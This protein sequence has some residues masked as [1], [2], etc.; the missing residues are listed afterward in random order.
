[1]R[2][3]PEDLRQVNPK[4][5]LDVAAYQIGEHLT[6]KAEA[7]TGLNGIWDSIEPHIQDIAKK[8]FGDVELPTEG[9]VLFNIV[10]AN[11]HLLGKKDK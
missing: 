4:G 3:P 10:R 1:M 11:P 5:R 9:K 7:H 2:K 6:K 8:L